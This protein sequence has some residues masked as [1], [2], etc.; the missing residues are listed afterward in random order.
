MHLAS[1]IKYDFEIK[2]LFNYPFNVL[3]TGGKTWKN[4]SRN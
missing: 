2:C 3:D 1:K 4:L